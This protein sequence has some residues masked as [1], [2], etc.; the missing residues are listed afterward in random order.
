ARVHLESFLQHDMAEFRRDF[1]KMT[2][3]DQR[4]AVRSILALTLWTL[5]DTDA[6][7]E[8][9]DAALREARD[10][11]YDLPICEALLW[12]TFTRHF[13]GRPVDEVEVH[14][15]ELRARA[16]R[17]AFNSHSAMAVALRALCAGRRGDTGSAVDGLRQ[18]LE[19]A[20]QAHYGPFDPLLVGELANCLAL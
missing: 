20:E 4:S 1:I 18:A 6:A 15:G 5:G 13:A 16:E 2:G 8:T 14:A 7:L 10:I 17:H 11:G 9:C 12:T 3:Y 19:L